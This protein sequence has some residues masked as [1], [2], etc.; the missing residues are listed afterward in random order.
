VVGGERAG[1]GREAEEGER[2]REKKKKRERGNGR[3]GEGEGGSERKVHRV[4]HKILFVS[5]LLRRTLFPA[6][7]T[8]VPVF[9]FHNSH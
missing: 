2:G 9:T 3:T 4:G 1:E 7:G 6:S 8:A 5:D